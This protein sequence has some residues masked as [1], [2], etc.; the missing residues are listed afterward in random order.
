VLAKEK[1]GICIGRMSMED[2]ISFFKTQPRHH[3]G[4]LKLQFPLCVECSSLFCL[5]QEAVGS[6]REDSAPPAP[7]TVWGTK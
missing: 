7:G 5:L 3:L 4:I 6:W 2:H 1:R